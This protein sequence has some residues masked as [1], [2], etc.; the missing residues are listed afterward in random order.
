MTAK[1]YLEETLRRRQ[2]LL[3]EMGRMAELL[4]RALGV[5]NCEQERLQELQG[6]ILRLVLHFPAA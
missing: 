4:R 5:A 6:G 2:E 1:T 3:E